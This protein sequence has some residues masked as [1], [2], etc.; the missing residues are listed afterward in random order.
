[1]INLQELIL[2]G[3]F[4]MADAPERLKV[5]EYVNGKHNAEDIS[6][7]TKR[8]VNNI[9]RDLVKLTDAEL[10]QPCLENGSPL[11]KDEFLVYEKVPLARTVPLRYFTSSAAKLDYGILKNACFSFLLREFINMCMLILL[12]SSI[13]YI[14]FIFFHFNQ[15][16]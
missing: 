2:R 11:K 14:F 5:F 12:F 7:L 13:Y 4:I 6:K 10:I 1:M 3:R 15:C 16:L 9:R 8:H